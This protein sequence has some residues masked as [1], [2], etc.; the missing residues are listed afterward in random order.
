[1]LDVKYVIGSTVLAAWLLIS[2]GTLRRCQMGHVSLTDR[3]IIVAN[4][5]I[6]SCL[7]CTFDHLDEILLGMCIHCHTRS[8]AEHKQQ[9]HK[10][11]CLLGSQQSPG[12]WRSPHSVV[13]VC[14]EK[15][16]QRRADVH[17][18]DSGIGA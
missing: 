12:R 7:V 18:H 17:K 15:L 9:Q 16:E 5:A 2:R 3:L 1:M 6:Y 4:E 11:S 10:L 13:A 14:R 8:T